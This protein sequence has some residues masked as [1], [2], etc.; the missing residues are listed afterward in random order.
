[1]RQ[2]SA[3]AACMAEGLVEHGLTVH[4]PGLV[5]HPSTS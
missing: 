3:N 1:M 4:Y 5:T 2:H